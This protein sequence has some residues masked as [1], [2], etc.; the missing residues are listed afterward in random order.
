[1]TT[2][3]PIDTSAS[4]AGGADRWRTARWRSGFTLIELIL[5][6][7]VLAAFAAVVVPNLSGFL[8]GRDLAHEGRRFVA[9]TQ[10]ARSEAISTGVGQ[11]VWM[12]PRNQR[13][14][15]REAPGFSRSTNATRV[16]PL[17]EKLELELDPTAAQ[18][19][20]EYAVR[21]LPDG[22][23]EEGSVTNL[24]IIRPDEERLFLA[25]STNGFNFEI[26]G[27]ERP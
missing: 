20:G 6:M 17:N 19:F 7:G 11:V 1:M 2:G 15:L 14:G 16:Y 27:N 8:K 24:A 18:A 4:P 21:F 25:L 10:F 3:R 12:D 23:I 5:V 13:Y 26:I 9:L 22:E